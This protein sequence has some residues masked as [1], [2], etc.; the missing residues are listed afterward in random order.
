MRP[1]LLAAALADSSVSTKDPLCFY[2]ANATTIDFRSIDSTVTKIYRRHLEKM[3]TIAIFERGRPPEFVWPVSPTGTTK[4]RPFA[5]LP[6]YARSAVVQEAQKGIMQC[7]KSVPF[8][9]YIFS[10]LNPE[11]FER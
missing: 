3:L 9:S 11:F 1:R 10:H 8:G 4:G 6:G 2:Q 7:F 5:K